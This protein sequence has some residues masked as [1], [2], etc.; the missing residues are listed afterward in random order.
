[1]NGVA[2][3]AKGANWVPAHAFPTAVGNDTYRDL[4]QGAADAHMN[5]LRVWGGG[6]Y[7]NDL[8]YDLC[9]ELGICVWQ[10]FMFA[11]CHVPLFDQRFVDN[12]CAEAEEQVQR[13]RHHACIALW[14]GNNEFEQDG[15]GPEGDP[16]RMQWDQYEPLF[17]RRLAAIV[18]THAPR[19]DYWPCSPHSPLGPREDYNNATCGDAHLWYVWGYDKPIH[20]Y[21]ACYHRFVSEF[22]FQSFPAP[23]TIEA[24]TRPADRRLDSRVMQLHQRSGSGNE[25]IM[26]HAREWFRV[27]KSF[28]NGVWLGQILQALAIQTGVEHWRRNRP[29]CM[30]AIYWM[31]N[32]CWPVVSW[33]SVDFHGRWKALHYAAR[34]FFA[35]L[36]VSGRFDAAKGAAEVFVCNDTRAAVKGRLTWTLSDAAGVAL[37]RGGAPVAASANAATRVR[38]VTLTKDMLAQGGVMLWLELSVAGKV[39]ARNLILLTKPKRLA[40]VDPAVSAS[41][42]ALD[43]D[44]YRVSLKAR[45]AALWIWLS[46]EGVDLRCED[47]FFHL[48][49]GRTVT[50][51]VTASRALDEEEFVKRLRVRSLVDTYA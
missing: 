7:E 16:D 22:G 21:L 51:T 34:R 28:E 13:L 35:P 5:M 41:V 9:D 4:L 32:D 6:F 12:V 49:P 40:L 10:D 38:R 48:R 36:V 17:D 39:I 46:A 31:L 2:F 3:F 37:A 1:V 18:A 15:V 23:R 30:G 33:S 14:C 8:F 27:P 42:R 29:R 19:T 26:R 44:R 43:D 25:K 45:A 11:C 20:D 47:N 50:I 24:F